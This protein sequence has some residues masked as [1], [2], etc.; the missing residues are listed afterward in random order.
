MELQDLKGF[1]IPD[2]KVSYIISVYISPKPELT[3]LY[4]RLEVQLPPLPQGTS[5]NRWNI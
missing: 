1:K 3:V 4:I 5:E 2:E